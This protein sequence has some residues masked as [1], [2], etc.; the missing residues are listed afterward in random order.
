MTQPGDVAVIT[1]AASGIGRGLA[2]IALARQMRVVLADIDRDT[3]HDLAASLQGD[4]TVV[5]VDVADA[6][7]VDALAVIAYDTYGQVDL[8]FNN[9]GVLLGGRSWDIPAA[10]WE[11]LIRVNV[12]GV[13]HGIASFVPRM[14]KANRPARVINTASVGGLLASPLLAPYS[15]SKF[16]VVALTEALAVELSLASA[17]V[18]ASVLCPGPVKTEIYRETLSMPGDTDSITAVERM[19]DY[20]FGTGISPDELARRAFAGIDA[21]QFW[22]ITHPEMVDDAYRRRSNAILERTIPRPE[23]Y[24]F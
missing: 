6:A 12:L 11:W 7:A 21:E 17:P 3:L 19:R 2:R 24:G 15:A 20:T 5:P 22:I 9:A 8:L 23:T 10:R 4:V 18:A 14:I 1:G 13:V 16:A